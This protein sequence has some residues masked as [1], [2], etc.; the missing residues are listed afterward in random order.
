MI[1][2]ILSGFLLIVVIYFGIRLREKKI[3]DDTQLR[4]YQ[5]SVANLKAQ[6]EDLQ[7]DICAQKDLIEENNEKIKSTKDEI[8]K[9]EAQYNRTMHDRTQELDAYFE[10]LRAARQQELDEYAKKA[11]SDNDELVRLQYENTLNT[12]QKFEEQAKERAECADRAAAQVIDEAF[13][14]ANKAIEGAK[15]EEAK[16]EAI[17]APLR[18]YEKEKQERLFYTIQVPDE[19][20]DDIEFLLTTVSQKIQ[21]PDVIN[22]L[23]WTEYVKPYIDNTFKRVGIEDKPGIYKLTSLVNGKCYVGKSTNIKKRI[24]DHL[25]STVGISTIADQAVH[26]AMAREGY[27]NWTIEPIIYCEKD[28]LNELEK[29]YIEFFKAQ[30]FGYNKNSGG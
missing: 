30:T 21:H 25:R 26:H 17:L 9:V 4:E 29:Y 22:K 24:S 11:K 13:D 7:K 3:L 18:Q 27:W 10:D 20:K 6:K 12:Y 15:E 16:F 23:V 14:R 28:K 8:N 2:W 1:A 19:Y 5:N